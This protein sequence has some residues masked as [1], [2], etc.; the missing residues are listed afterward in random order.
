MV[1]PSIEE[2]AGAHRLATQWLSDIGAVDLIAARLPK[3][4]VERSCTDTGAGCNKDWGHD[5]AQVQQSLA[6]LE[7]QLAL[8]IHRELKKGGLD[9]GGGG[10]STLHLDHVGNVLA[11]RGDGN[12]N[13]GPKPSRKVCPA[14]PGL[15]QDHASAGWRKVA[16]AASRRSSDGSTIRDG[17]SLL[18]ERV[19]P[20]EA[21]CKS[22]MQGA[23]DGIDATAT[24]G[25]VSTSFTVCPSASSVA[26]S[27]MIALPSGGMS[28][29]PQSSLGDRLDQDISVGWSIVP[30]TA[31]HGID[32]DGPL[33]GTINFPPGSTVTTLTIPLLSS[34]N[35]SGKNSPQGSSMTS[36]TSSSSEDDSIPA[37]RTMNL[38]LSS[39]TSDGD[40]SLSVHP[41][42]GEATVSIITQG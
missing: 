15:D 25:F 9:V 32:F 27:V 7:G 11:E 40:V 12:S 3:R 22:S 39:P 13:T 6:G 36:R 16:T 28:P 37:L 17:S 42:L 5:E 35:E 4:A 14:G 41:S 8:L 10:T 31:V 1:A 29:P 21:L 30:G 24:V 18:R 23:V 2:S 38:L 20:D 33:T 34:V 26:V 19:A